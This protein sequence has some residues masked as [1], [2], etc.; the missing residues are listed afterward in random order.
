VRDGY[1]ESKVRLAQG[2]PEMGVVMTGGTTVSETVPQA[3]GRLRAEELSEELDGLESSKR[4]EFMRAFMDSLRNNYGG[5]QVSAW[6][7]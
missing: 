1:T 3:E 6:T 2:L 7:M 5:L 4:D